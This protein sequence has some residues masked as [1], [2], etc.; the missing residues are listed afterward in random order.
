M[1][2]YYY[3]MIGAGYIIDNKKA[4]QIMELPDYEDQYEGHLYCLDPFFNDSEWFFG[5]VIQKAELGYP[6]GIDTTDQYLI[7]LLNAKKKYG[8][9]LNI[10]NKYT[11]D[12]YLM[13]RVG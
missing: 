13:V 9:V 8:S 10:D 12:T 6:N 3:A 7:D 1:G 11:L 4:E 2:V 5:T